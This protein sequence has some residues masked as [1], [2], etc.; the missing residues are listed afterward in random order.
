MLASNK[1]ANVSVG[2]VIAALPA[3]NGVKRRQVSAAMTMPTDTLARLLLASTFHANLPWHAFCSQASFMQTALGTYP[4]T[5]PA[6]SGA[7]VLACS[8]RRVIEH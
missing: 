2:M 8:R 5:D 4:A 7:N 3:L 1:R 6:L